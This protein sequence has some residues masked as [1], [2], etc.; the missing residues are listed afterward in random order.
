MKLHEDII[1]KKIPKQHLDRCIAKFNEN[2]RFLE[3][4]E[5]CNYDY[6][7]FIFRRHGD[8]GII[9]CKRCHLEFPQSMKMHINNNQGCPDCSHKDAMI[10]LKLKRESEFE[11]RGR[12]NHGELCDYSDV[13]Y[14]NSYTP[15]KIF[16]RDH[17][18]YFYQTP[19]QHY[20]NKTTSCTTCIQIS[21]DKHYKENIDIRKNLF[22][23]RSV[24]LHKDKFDYSKVIY[25][26]TITPVKIFCKECKVYITVTPMYHSYGNGCP[27]CAE[28]IDTKDNRY[29]KYYDKPTILYYIEIEHKNKLYYKIGITS[30]TVKER[31][32]K[33]KLSYKVIK[34]EYFETG[35][36]AYY[37]E[38][39]I[40]NSLIKY[41]YEGEP[42]IDNGGNTEIFIEDCYMR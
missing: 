38:Q 25:V 31:F 24:T 5:D 1:N 30:N 21:R 7:K 17:N 6:S 42:I 26:N 39:M 41:K 34:E 19:T 32:R 14:I 22:I 8:K 9:I 16:C 3:S 13:N 40:L 12:A 2:V 4:I 35:E 36:P 10:K 37:K 29:I 23:K 18:E 33:D 28:K 20:T 15:V 27:H 11:G